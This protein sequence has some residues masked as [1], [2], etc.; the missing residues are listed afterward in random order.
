MAEERSYTGRF[1][2]DSE[3]HLRDRSNA[4]Y[5]S[6]D[7]LFR[8]LVYLFVSALVSEIAH[9]GMLSRHWKEQAELFAGWMDSTVATPCRDRPGVA[10]CY[11][12]APRY[13]KVSASHSSLSR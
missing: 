1:L 5:Q 7:L 4:L 8:G 9:D 13:R 10:P 2:F 12:C 6:S 3:K 11:S